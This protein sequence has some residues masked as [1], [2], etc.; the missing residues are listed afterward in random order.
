MYDKYTLSIYFQ[1]VFLKDKNFVRIKRSLTAF[2]LFAATIFL[3]KNT[4][5]IRSN[6]LS[7]YSWPSNPCINYLNRKVGELPKIK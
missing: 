5:I 7:N 6:K 1:G 4:F 2:S 3:T